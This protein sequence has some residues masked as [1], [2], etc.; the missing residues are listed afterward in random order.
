MRRIGVIINTQSGSS[1][2]PNIAAI[3]QA[4]LRRHADFELELVQGSQIKETAQRMLAG[5]SEVVAIGGGD[6]SVNAA[7]A[8]VVGHSAVLG[9][10]PLGTLNHFAG[11]LGIPLQSAEAA[12]ILVREQ[13]AKVDFATVNG[14]LFLNNSGIGLYPSL[15]RRREI[16]EPHIGKWPAAAVAAIR[17]WVRPFK[18]M[19]LQIDC[20]GKTERVKTPFVFVGNND[21]RIDAQGLNN[22][23]RLDEGCLVVYAHK[24]GNRLKLIWNGL[25]TMLGLHSHL[26]WLVMRGDQ[27]TI[28]GP[29]ASLDVSIDGE[30]Q[31]LSLPLEYQIHHRGLTVLA[32]HGKS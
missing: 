4:L 23:K 15:V 5:G 16:E 22:R 6:G 18:C 31:S 1:L 3:K 28:S 20:G 8:E 12:E 21:Y 29:P 14:R 2:E 24:G 30:I 7:A 19:E 26:D 25:L 17:L 13:K 10:L 9:V 32:P 11:D 27:A